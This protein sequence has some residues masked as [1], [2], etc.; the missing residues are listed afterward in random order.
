VPRKSDYGKRALC[1]SDTD[2]DT[3]DDDSTS[4]DEDRK[5]EN[6]KGPKNEEKCTIKKRRKQYK[7]VDTPS[8]NQHTPVKDKV[9]PENKE[10]EDKDQASSSHKKSK[11][12]AKR[13]P[14]DAS[15]GSF[16]Q[17]S[18]EIKRLKHG[19]LETDEDSSDD[20][21]SQSDQSDTDDQDD[22]ISTL[23][24]KVLPEIKSTSHDDNE[25]DEQP[26]TIASQQLTGNEIITNTRPFNPTAFG[27][28]FSG[29]LP[30]S[31]EGA[32]SATCRSP[33]HLKSPEEKE[34]ELEESTKK[35]FN[36]VSKLRED[37]RNSMKRA[38]DLLKAAFSESDS[39]SECSENE[40][41][42]QSD[43]RSLSDSD[44]DI[45]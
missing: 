5:I 11:I 30:K 12:G 35:E 34:T 19:E 20:S 8:K 25:P 1:T 45:S 42:S 18:E 13:K 43:S 7:S 24:Q 44:I 27:S 2:E 33:G 28:F 3:S 41:R 37:Q 10:L 15:R 39:D 23:P 31:Y 36:D 16:S 40:E 6:K 29:G 14:T 4:E 32:L 22:E 26:Y 9:A 21:E 17:E 38:K